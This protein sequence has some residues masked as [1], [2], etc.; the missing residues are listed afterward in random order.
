MRRTW[1]KLDNFYQQFDL[2][3]PK[4]TCNSSC[5]KPTTSKPNK[6]P[7]KRIAHKY[8]KYFYSK[9]DPYYKNTT[10]KLTK[11]FQSKLKS[12]KKFDPKNITCYK[13]G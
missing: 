12:K 2:S 7:H 13:Y 1:Q 5:S 4:P 3:L 10:K 11:P 8:S 9:I 6:P